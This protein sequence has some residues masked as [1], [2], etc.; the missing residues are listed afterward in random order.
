[1]NPFIDIKN[2]YDEQYGS[3]IIENLLKGVSNEVI[4]I[5]LKVPLFI[6]YERI[7]EHIMNH[8]YSKLIGFK[9]QGLNGDK[10]EMM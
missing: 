10:N 8:D 5:D 2:S 3:A 9:L 7:Y 4:S 6:D 1:M